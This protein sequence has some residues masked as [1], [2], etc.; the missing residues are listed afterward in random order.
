MIDVRKEEL[1]AWARRKD[2][3]IP[4]TAVL[5]PVSDDASFRRYFRFDQG[6]DGLVYVD[7]PPE[8]E[9]NK[10]FVRVSE[11]LRE[12]GLV[13]PKVMDHDFEKGWMVLS[14]LGDTLY[15]SEITA[16][17]EK[18]EDLYRQAVSAL[19]TMQGADCDLE[20]Y[21]RSKLQM[22]MSLFDEWFL[23]HQLNLRIDAAFMLRL[24][25][26]YEVLIQNA[27]EQP[28]CF[29]HRDYH[30]RNLMVLDVGNPGIIDFQDAVIGPV[31]YDLVSLYK[32]CYHRFDRQTVESVV[33]EFRCEL[34][35]DGV[36]SSGDDLLRWFDLMGAQRHLKCA[37]IFSRL[38]LRDG[39][40]GYLPDI[41]L[42]IDYLVEVA[43]IYEELSDLGDWLVDAVQPK[44]TSPEYRR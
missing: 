9:D 2:R 33:E 37:G 14:D 36:V 8:H 23:Q 43:G 16:H 42:V 39:K 15:L 35:E 26:V 21:N 10:G 44:L 5:R 24:Q 31:T 25:E 32:D 19:R 18:T 30:C 6:A 29:V 22:E 27:L 11:A 20:S 38:N 1:S 13:C 34:V 4:G 12:A 41:P 40:P 7:A 17:P 3:A 28:Q